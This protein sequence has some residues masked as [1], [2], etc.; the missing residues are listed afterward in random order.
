MGLTNSQIDKLG[1]RLRAGQPT[2]SDLIALSTYRNGFALPAK[3]VFDVV[4]AVS[5]L[6]PTIRSEKTTLSVVAKL[7]REG[8]RLSQ[9]QDISGCRV[10]VENLAAQDV[11]VN[12]LMTRFPDAKLYDRCLQPAHGY[13]AKHVVAKHSG[14]W[15]E[16]QIRTTVQH[17]WALLSEKAADMFGQDVKYGT[18]DKDVLAELALI[19]TK[20][21]EAESSSA[22]FDAEQ[23][24][25]IDKNVT[26]FWERKLRRKISKT[27]QDP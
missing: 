17:R 7:R 4:Q 3:A 21:A 14:K 18:G 5:G 2:E 19:S 24:V 11:L 25:R 12:I 23:M 1:E 16:I 6:Q 20:F 27:R 26:D 15:I 9:I 10:T 8:I 22:N 13:R